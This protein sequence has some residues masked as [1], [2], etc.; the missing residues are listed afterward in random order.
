MR[1]LPGHVKLVQPFPDSSESR[2]VNPSPQVRPETSS[3]CAHIIVHRPDPRID[4][5]MNLPTPGSG[6]W[7]MP[8]HKGMPVCPEDIRV[9]RNAPERERR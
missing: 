3:K 6:K 9:L 5:E 4:P 2:Q 7:N 1:K 8:V